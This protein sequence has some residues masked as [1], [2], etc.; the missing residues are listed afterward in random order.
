MLVE[1]QNL[2]FHEHAVVS[3]GKWLL[4]DFND[5]CN[6][7]TDVFAVLCRLGSKGLMVS[8]EPIAQNK[9]QLYELCWNNSKSA[10]WGI[11]NAAS[12]LLLLQWIL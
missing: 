3:W 10:S 6:F 11:E 4:R 1:K 8:S 12:G 9:L 2:L 5:C 7:I